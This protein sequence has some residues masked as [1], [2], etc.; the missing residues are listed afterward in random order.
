MIEKPPSTGNAVPVTKSD[1]L[2]ARNTAMPASS[3]IAP[4]P[5]ERVRGFADV[6]AGVVDENVD[7]AELPPDALD[8]GRDRGL[9]GDISGDRYRPGAALLELGDRGSRFRFVA[10]DDR[11]ACAGIRQTPRHA[12]ANAAIA[13]GDN[14]DFAAEIE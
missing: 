11:N 9:V 10:P 3:T 12:K 14:G 6:D 5:A 8:H 7:P 13:A 2:D 4:H 1:A